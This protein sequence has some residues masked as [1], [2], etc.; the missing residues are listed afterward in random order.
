MSLQYLETRRRADGRMRWK[1]GTGARVAVVTGD[2]PG[3]GPTARSSTMRTRAT[4]ISLSCRPTDAGASSDFCWEYDRTRRQASRYPRPNDQADRRLSHLSVSE[5]VLVPTD[6]AD[7]RTRS[8][9]R[10]RYRERGRCN[11]HLLSAIRPHLSASR[12]GAISGDDDQDTATDILEDASAFLSGCWR[13]VGETVRSIP[14]HRFLRRSLN[15]RDHDV[16]HRHRHPHGR[17]GYSAIPF[18]ERP[19]APRA[20]VTGPRCTT[21]RST[22]WGSSDSARAD[23]ISAQG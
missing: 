21:V 19:R 4:S 12:S 6:P 23:A 15:H 18:W 16:D 1:S 3:P 8:K 9:I 2:P 5:R 20:D 10:N 13:R 14:A 11:V 22:A 7:A 17:T